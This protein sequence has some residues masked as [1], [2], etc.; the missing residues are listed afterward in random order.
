MKIALAQINPTVGNLAGN[1]AKIVDFAARAQAAGAGLVVF[2]ELALPGYPPKDLLDRPYFVD[3]VLETFDELVRRLP[4]VPALVGTIVRNPDR[5]GRSLFNAATL[6]EGGRVR[7]VH[8]KALLPAYDVFDE[9]R[10]FEPGKTVVVESAGGIPLGLSICEDLWNDAE[11]WPRP[12]YHWDPI[13]A[14]AERGAGLI[15]NLSASPWTVGKERARLE[16]IRAQARRFRRPFLYC[17]QVGGNDELL[18]DGNSFALDAGG[19]LVAKARAFEEDLLVVDPAAGPGAVADA[20]LD[21]VEAVWRA[22]VMGTRDYARKCG[23]RR[24]VVGLSGGVDSAVTAAVAAAALGPAN[25]LGVAMPSRFNLAETMSDAERVARNLG[26]QFMSVSIEGVFESY[27][28]AFQQLFPGS[29]AD[30]TEENVQARIRGTLLMAVSNKLGHLVLSTGNKSELAMGYC[31]LY[32]DMCGGLAVIS[33]LPK[34]LVYRVGARVNRER[35]IIPRSTLERAPT[36]E[37]RP[38][39]KDSDTLPEYPVLDPILKACIEDLKSPAAILATGADPKAVAEVFRKVDANEY[40]RRQA[41]PGLKVTT[42]AFG[43]GRRMPI[44]Q[45]YRP[46]TAR[47]EGME[48]G[49]GG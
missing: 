26:I 42:K 11:Y 18:F 6:V 24:A 47:A 5:A 17:N 23:F 21:D 40:K 46:R 44:A 19:E 37:L 25:V 43:F 1:A 39:Q 45:G 35:E 48:E 20:A 15:V 27:L 2:P 33:D 13:A 7:A 3:D 41:A 36:A 12:L 28:K 4:P 16:M 38:N 9:A 8:H 29:P 22:L 49:K 14:L 34:D 32:G 10:Y 31:T 30:V